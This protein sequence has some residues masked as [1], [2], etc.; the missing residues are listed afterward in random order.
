MINSVDDLPPPVFDLP[1]PVADVILPPVMEGGYCDPWYNG[2]NGTNG[3]NGH[4]ADEVDDKA[5]DEE[6]ESKEAGRK[7]YVSL[8]SPTGFVP[9]SFGDAANTNGDSKAN[10]QD[11]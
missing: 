6:N 8:V 3:T 2:S 4:T 7:S 5:S 11:D 1:S 9:S 10:D